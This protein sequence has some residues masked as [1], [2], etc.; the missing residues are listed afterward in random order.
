MSSL[1]KLP[2]KTRAELRAALLARFIP[3]KLDWIP[4]NKQAVA[5]K[6][7]SEVLEAL[8][9]GAAGGGKSHFV[10]Y[11]AVQYC[12]DNPMVHVGIVRKTLP[13]LKQTQ[14]LTLRPLLHQLATFNASDFTWTF[15]NGSI[16]RFISLPHEG[17]EQNYKST[18]FDRLYFEEITELT[19]A[20][21][22]YMLTRL[23]SKTGLK[24]S[25]FATANPEGVGYAWVRRRWVTPDDKEICDG[26]SKPEPF[27]VWH[28]A[29]PGTGEPGPA[30]VFIPATV[31]DNSYLMEQQPDYVRQ[32][33]AIP[34]ARRRAAL[35][36]GDW[37]AMSQVEGALFDIDIIDK[38]RVHQIP[39]DA[40]GRSLLE[41]IVVAVDP[42]VTFTETSDSTGIIVAASIGG[43]ADKEYWILEDCT[44]RAEPLDW[45]RA[46]VLA[47]W[48][49]TAGDIV[50]ER[51]NGGLTIRDTIITAARQLLEEGIIDYMPEVRLERAR[52]AGNKSVR[53]QPVSAL[54]R[55]G[56]VHHVGTFPE[57]ETQ[58]TTWT[59]EH[60]KTSPDRLDAAVWAVRHLAKKT[61]GIGGAF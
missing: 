60:K 59:P 15:P 45:G 42:A 19:E 28:P 31:Y 53:A 41:R 54:Y 5:L 7:R 3:I 46:A 30:R 8:Y 22:T 44:V 9:G 51:D 34:D 12:L 25:A 17:D 16:L 14:L 55:A 26:H 50:A 58:M 35:L 11:D 18:E 52:D 56:K 36:N 27:E 57:L 40:N 43:R 39:Q 2:A 1:E 49:W 23:R 38:Y 33:E 29:Q 13:M 6:L 48:K 24:V 4:T 61:Q 20:Q 47:W 32:L 21:Y 10:S 37:E